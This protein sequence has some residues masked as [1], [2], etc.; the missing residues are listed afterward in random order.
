MTHEDKI[1]YMKVAAGIVG[2]GFDAKGLDML[3]S[4]YDK[5]LEKKGDTDLK[6]LVDIQLRVERKWKEFEMGRVLLTPE[7]P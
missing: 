4:L 7:I 2:Y 5:V 6:D 1:T 3:L